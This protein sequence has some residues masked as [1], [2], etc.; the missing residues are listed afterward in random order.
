LQHAISARNETIVHGRAAPVDADEI[1]LNAGRAAAAAPASA[2]NSVV[3][4]V[5]MDDDDG[6]NGLGAPHVRICACMTSAIHTACLEKM[7]NSKKSRARPIAERTRCM[8]CNSAFTLPLQPYVLSTV[9]LPWRVEQALRTPTGQLLIRLLPVLGLAMHVFG[10][11]FLLYSKDFISIKYLVLSM[12][13]LLVLERVRAWR[14]RRI[15]EMDDVEFHAQTVAYARR[16]VQL[17]RGPSA[18]QVSSAPPHQLVLL[19]QTAAAATTAAARPREIEEGACGCYGRGGGC[20]KMRGS[21]IAV[22]AAASTTTRAS[23]DTLT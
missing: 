7:L 9:V 8:V 22:P 23:V 5:C 4:Y 15:A 17:G 11:A 1:D 16:E 12:L 6:T 14:R 2:D 3:C 10:F 13:P 19:V 18:A 20:V 21:V